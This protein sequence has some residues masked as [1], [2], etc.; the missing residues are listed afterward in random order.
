MGLMGLC[1]HDDE[2]EKLHRGEQ[3]VKVYNDPIGLNF[4]DAEHIR[5]Y[6][7]HSFDEVTFM[8]RIVGHRTWQRGKG[9]KR[10][11]YS[12]EYTFEEVKQ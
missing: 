6:T 12:Y 7:Q 1:F 5:A 10:F 8:V 3:V 4:S 11:H 2:I 9:R